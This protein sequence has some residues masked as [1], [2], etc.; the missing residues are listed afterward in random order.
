[1]PVVRAG[2]PPLGGEAGGGGGE[3][4]VR[5]AGVAGS[6]MRVLDLFGCSINYDRRGAR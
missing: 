4:V 6:A 3:V 5:G 2:K 1:M